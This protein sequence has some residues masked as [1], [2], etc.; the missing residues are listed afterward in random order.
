MSQIVSSD[1]RRERDAPLSEQAYRALRSA[2]MAGAYRP[3]DKLKME[4]LQDSFSFSSTPL[5]EALNRLVVEGLVTADERRGFRAAVLSESDLMDLTA[6]RLVCEPGALAVS[7]LRGD[8]EWES[9]VVAAHHRLEWIEKRIA[10]N[11]LAHNED[12]TARHKDFHMALIA[13]CRSERLLNVCSNLFDQAERY[14]RASVQVRTK[15]RD[16]SSEHR[17]LMQA[18]LGREGPRAAQLLERHISLT[19]DNLLK[20]MGEKSLGQ[21]K[22]KPQSTPKK[23]GK[24]N[25]QSH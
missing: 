10:N 12:W 11:E 3:G 16:I 4:A 21:P 24:K 8:D 25:G 20:H 19:T 15:P 14:R 6:A 17:A 13:G 9:R 22:G 2:I 5:R 1:S 18:A 7:V 23:H